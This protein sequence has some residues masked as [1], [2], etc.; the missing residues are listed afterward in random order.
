MKLAP[1]QFDLVVMDPPRWAKSVFGAVDLVRDYQSIFKPALL[2][3]KPGGT[4]LCTNHV[5]RV[6]L[7]G[8]LNILER[9]GEK[10]GRPLND[11]KT[12]KPEEDFPAKDGRHP[13]KIAV[14]KV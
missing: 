1:R 11:I 10:A 13:L 12:I 4:I 9:C 7:D 14:V 8:W 5:P 6:D 3:T 2:A